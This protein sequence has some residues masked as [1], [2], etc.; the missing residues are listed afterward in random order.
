[1]TPAACPL[2]GLVDAHFASRIRPAEE[3]RMR[4]HL[5]DCPDC[6]RRYERQLLLA[7]LTPSA[8]DAKTRLA[9]GLGLRLKRPFP[10][11]RLPALGAA[12]ATAA[13]LSLVLLVPRGPSGVDDGFTARGGA[14]RVDEPAPPLLGYRL[15]PDGGSEPLS[16]AMDARDELAFAYR[17][18]EGRPFLMVFGVDEHGHVYWYHPSWSDAATNPSAVPVASGA[19]MVELPEA[20]SQ[21]L[22]GQELSLHAVF[23]DSPWTVRQMEDWLARGPDAVS[24]VPGATVY[25]QRVEVRP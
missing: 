5:P 22:D 2:R 8:P 9:R 16:R 1:M 12:L 6:H 4:Q 14:A 20:I 18:P 3:Q 19:A 17:N 7:E 23:M 10:S 11:L 24:E 13:A 21:H 25:S 15:T